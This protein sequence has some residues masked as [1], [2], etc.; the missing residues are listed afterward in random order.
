MSTFPLMC[1]AV[2]QGIGVALFLQNSSLNNDNLCQISLEEMPEPLHT[3]L[4]STKDR[5]RLKLVSEFIKAA[6]E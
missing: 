5:S 2:A 6:I 4:V 1:E 3:Y